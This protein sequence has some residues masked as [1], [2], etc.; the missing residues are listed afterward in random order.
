MKPRY[1]G[2]MVIL[3]RTTGGSSLL[4]ELDGGVSR[5]RYA[6][7][8]LIPTILVFH[9]LFISQN[10]QIQMMKTW[11]SWQEKTWKSLMKK[12]KTLMS[13]TSPGI[14]H[15]RPTLMIFLIIL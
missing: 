2:P 12:T 13:Q 15:Q 11:I 8:P 10:S 3:Y 1:L 5:L 6:T 9:L 14:C 4:A 7:F